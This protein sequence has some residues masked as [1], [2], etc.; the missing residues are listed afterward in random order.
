[1]GSGDGW[2]EGSG[3]EKMETTVLKQQKKCGKKTNGGELTKKKRS[4]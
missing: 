1:M 3:G 4:L 2:G